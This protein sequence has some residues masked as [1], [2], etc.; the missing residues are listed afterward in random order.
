[1]ANA[2]DMA[3][4]KP[5]Y[6]DKGKLV[7]RHLSRRSGREGFDRIGG[8]KRRANVLVFKHDD[9]SDTKIT[10]QKSMDQIRSITKEKRMMPRDQEPR[11]GDFVVTSCLENKTIEVGRQATTHGNDS[12]LK[13]DN[14]GAYEIMETVRGR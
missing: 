1:M 13:L 7:G 3:S 14:V 4:A 6:L 12:I 8:L 5:I 11:R 2:D 10:S 9:R